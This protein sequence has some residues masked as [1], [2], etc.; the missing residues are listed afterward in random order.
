ME[1]VWGDDLNLSLLMALAGAVQGVRQRLLPLLAA[2]GLTGGQFETLKALQKRGPLG[3]HELLGETMT[4]SGNIDVVLN[5]LL[6]KR[7]ITKTLDPADGRRRIVSLTARGRSYVGKRLPVHV[8]ELRTVLGVLTTT[9]KRQ[10]QVLL[11]RLGMKE[12]QGGCRGVL[13]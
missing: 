11:G 13:Q 9:E 5:N 3:M 6:R 7:M 4:T 10:L 12:T 8:R 2:D 1:P